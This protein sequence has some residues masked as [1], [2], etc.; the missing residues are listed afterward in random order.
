MKLGTDA[1]TTGWNY[2]I[3]TGS[4]EVMPDV[5]HPQF[6]NTKTVFSKQFETKLVLLLTCDCHPLPTE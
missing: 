2:P 1:L 3:G 6:Q 4:S 5:S